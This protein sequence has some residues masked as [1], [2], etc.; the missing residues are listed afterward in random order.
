M[1]LYIRSIEDKKQTIEKERKKLRRNSPHRLTGVRISNSWRS[2]SAYKYWNGFEIKTLIDAFDW[3]ILAGFNLF[4]A[5]LFNALRTR[6]L[7]RL[8]RMENFWNSLA[9]AR[10]SLILFLLSLLSS[11]FIHCEWML[12]NDWKSE[13]NVSDH[14]SI[15]IL[16]FVYD[17]V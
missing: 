17:F 1:S 13:R 5:R 7:R 10:K 3:I 16:F 9:P 15:C 4:I 2:Q 8:S 14:Y 6:C 11:S 12:L